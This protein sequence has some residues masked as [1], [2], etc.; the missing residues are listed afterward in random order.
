MIH[1]LMV[2]EHNYKFIVSM[3]GLRIKH[4][5]YGLDTRNLGLELNLDKVWWYYVVC[6]H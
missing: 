5:I 2:H 6:S 3:V 1:A 4:F